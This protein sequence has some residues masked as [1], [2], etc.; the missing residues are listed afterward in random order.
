MTLDEVRRDLPD[1][2]RRKM[3]EGAKDGQTLDPSDLLKVFAAYYRTGQRIKVRYT[4]GTETEIKFGRVGITTGWRPVFLLVKA[5]HHI[6]SSDL[7]TGN[8]ELIGVQVRPGGPY[9]ARSV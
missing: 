8:V 2:Y 1:L 6:G 4:W 9:V 3:A 7:L 5:S